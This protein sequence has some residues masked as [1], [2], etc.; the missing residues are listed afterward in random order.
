MHL[1]NST[2]M[3]RERRS[4][5]G[6]DAGREPWDSGGRSY[7]W[8]G[9]KRGRAERGWVLVHAAGGIA[10]PARPRPAIRVWGEHPIGCGLE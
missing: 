10:L 1:A 8:M 9:R 2:S 3:V 7:G 4:F 5:P 6:G